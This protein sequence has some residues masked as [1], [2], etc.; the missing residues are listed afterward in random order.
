MYAEMVAIQLTFRIQNI[1]IPNSQ[2]VLNV[3]NL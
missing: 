1:Q 2:L 3:P